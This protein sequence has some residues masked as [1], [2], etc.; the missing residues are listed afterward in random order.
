MK[1]TVFGSTGGTG[2]VL[3]EEGARR[4]YEIT[5]FARQASALDGV[6]G[7]AEIVQGD[8]RDPEPVARAVE[9]RDAVIVTVAGRGESGVATAIA[10]TV[11]AAMLDT[12]VRRLIATSAYGM[13]ATRPYVM[14][15]LVR[16]LFGKAFSDQQA[17]DE[18]IAASGLEWTIVRATRLVASAA[19]DAGPRLS[20]EHFAK[21]PWSLSRAAYAS[22]LLDLAQAGMYLR[23]TVNTSG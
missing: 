18:V 17:A 16:R 15:P 3:I 22:E 11:T 4:G 20:T 23:E 10:R 5:A 19:P 14:A 2:R 7:L 9:G 13:V 12:N 1:I 21:G 8:A 6:A